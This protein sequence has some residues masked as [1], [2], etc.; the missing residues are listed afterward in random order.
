MARVRRIKVKEQALWER[1][2]SRGEKSSRQSFF[3]FYYY[4]LFYLG[5]A[6]SLRQA[7]LRG[8]FADP[9]QCV[10]QGNFIYSDCRDAWVDL[11]PGQ[12]VGN[13]RVSGGSNLGPWACYVRMLTKRPPPM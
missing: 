4:F 1:R 12:H 13:P 2:E 8:H 6:P 3:L 7:L 9:S 11:R 10:S 5:A